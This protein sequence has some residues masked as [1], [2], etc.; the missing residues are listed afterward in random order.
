MKRVLM[1]I[2]GGVLVLRLLPDKWPARLAQA[3]TEHI[4]QMPDG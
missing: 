2:I 1:L 4:E 3:L